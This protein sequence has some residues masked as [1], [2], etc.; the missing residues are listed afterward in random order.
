MKARQSSHKIWRRDITNV[1]VRGAVGDIRVSAFLNEE[2]SVP[3]DITLDGNPLS[4]R[5]LRWAAGAR[6]FR[7][8][9][10]KGTWI[11][12]LGSQRDGAGVSCSRF[13]FSL[14]LGGKPRQH[15][16]LIR[17]VPVGVQV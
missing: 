13:F 8:E 10:L 7:E 17:A 5:L 3:A 6:H 9:Q 14:L 1:M 12:A 2:N 15:R 11:Q 16:L 4:V